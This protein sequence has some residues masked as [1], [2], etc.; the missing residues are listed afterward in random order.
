MVDYAFLTPAEVV[1]VLEVVVAPGVAGLHPLLA[2]VASLSPPS[3]MCHY[4]R[5]DLRRGIAMV[6]DRHRYLSDLFPPL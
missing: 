4:C 3:S 6:S 5:H 1:V 2:V